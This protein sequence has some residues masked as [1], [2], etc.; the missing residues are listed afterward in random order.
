M[1]LLVQN[2]AWFIG[3]PFIPERTAG[4]VKGGGDQMW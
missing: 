3:L 1:G 4:A 2:V